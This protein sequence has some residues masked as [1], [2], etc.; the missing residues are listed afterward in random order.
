MQLIFAIFHDYNYEL[1]PGQN[2]G[3]NS[4]QLLAPKNVCFDFYYALVG[5]SILICS[6]FVI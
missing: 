1:G 6:N 4:F 5:V 3:Q 2:F